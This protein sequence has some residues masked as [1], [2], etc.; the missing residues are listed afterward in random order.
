MAQPNDAE[1]LRAAWRALSYHVEGAG[2]STIGIGRYGPVRVMAGRHFPGNEE[3][4]LAGF[5]GVSLP[6]SLRMPAGR[7]FTV[8]RPDL[9][10]EGVKANW[11]SLSRHEG[12]SQDLFASMAEDVLGVLRVLQGGSEQGLLRAFLTRI[13]AWQDFMERERE[14]VL[15]REAEVGLIGELV[16]LRQLLASGLP[17]TKVIESW[18][19]PLDGIHDFVIGCGAIEVKSTIAPVGFLATIGSLEQLDDAL[20]SPLFVACVRLPLHEQ[21]KTLPELADGVRHD[22]MHDH[23]SASLFESRLLHAG[24]LSSQAPRYTRRFTPS[25]PRILPVTGALPRIT[26]QSVMAGVRRVRY[27]IDLDGTG[28]LEIPLARAMEQLGVSTKWN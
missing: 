23:I 21:G 8:S 16:L 6:D 19:G 15:G 1:S 3:A 20:V 18:Q 22:L 11:I 4:L 27:E 28:L 9:G 7:G 10:T 25:A 12:G 2:W 17:P 5:P 24:F 13:A 26:Q 14:D